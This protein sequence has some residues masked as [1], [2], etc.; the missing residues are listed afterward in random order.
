MKIIFTKEQTSEEFIKEMELKYGNMEI[1]EKEIEKE[2]NALKV[3]DLDSWK[4][5]KENP[6]ETIKKTRTKLTNDI[7]TLDLDLLNII[8]KEHPESVKDL[9]K[10]TNKDVN[11]I[12]N[13]ID[14]LNETGLI[15]Y[16]KNTKIPVVS[17]DEVTIAI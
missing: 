11:I 7:K 5:L 6:N 2:Y 14:Y 10:L 12:K 3:V 1:L 15:E 13:K 17:F 9:A 16:K 4:F 8:K